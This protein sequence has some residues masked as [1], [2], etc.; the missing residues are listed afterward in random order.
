MLQRISYSVYRYIIMKNQEYNIGLDVGTNS[1]GWCVIDLEG[2]LLQFRKKNMWGARLFEAGETAEKC[3]LH[4][5]TRRRYERRRQ[6]IH[7]LQEIME[8]MI[9]DVD[10][11]FFIRLDEAFLW[12]EDKKVKTDYILF[13]D[14]GYTDI[15]FYK[16]YPTRYHLRKYLINTDEK[17]DPRMI[18]LT[19][20]HMIK[21]RG[22]FLYQGQKF[23][24]IASAQEAFKI[25][26][27]ELMDQL[28]IEITY[29]EECF[30][31]IETILKGEK[32]GKKTKQE[33]VVELLTK[34]GVDKKYAKELV[35]AFLGYSFDLTK[36]MKD[37]ELRD[38]NEKTIKVAFKDA[39][40]EETEA[41]LKDL[42]GE[43][44]SVVEALKRIYSWMA[45]EETL[46][47]KQY[48]SEAMVDKY[49]KHHKELAKLKALFRKYFTKEEYI[50]FFREEKMNGK[51]K[52]A[53]TYANYIQGT[54]RCDK[55]SL[56]DEIKKL[57]DKAAKED[58]DYQAALIEME[59]EEYLSKQN[60]VNNAYIPY[61]LNEMEL[62]LILQKQ[63]EFYP[64]L[65]ENKQKILKLLTF[66]IPYF[67]G[68]LNPYQHNQQ[69]NFAWM[70]KKEGKE[71]EKI[72][73]WNFNEVVDIDQTAEK[74][75]T[76]M[77]SFCTYLPEEKVLPKYSLLYA[78]YEVF[79][80]L[81]KIR[82]DGRL[83]PV[84]DKKKII[85]E[86]F[87]K[88]KNVTDKAFK[89]W[90]IRTQYGKVKEENEEYEVTGY[91]KE[92]GF[93]SSLTAYIDFTHI[94]GEIT[95]ENTKMIEELIYWLTVFEERDIVKRK[96]KQKYGEKITQ[97][98][99]K[100]I[101]KLQYTGWGKLSEK[102]LNGI[103]GYNKRH[104]KV[105][106][107]DVLRE[108]RRNLN[109]MQIINDREMEFYDII[110]EKRKRLDEN[111]TLL[112]AVNDL[113]G[114]PAIK[115]GIWQSLQIIE[116][117]IKIMDGV[118][119]QQIFI[120]FAREQGEKVRTTT[121]ARQLQNAYKKLKEEVKDFNAQ[122]EEELKNKENQ[123]KLDEEKAYLY[124]LQN[125]KSLYSGET[126]NLGELES[127]EVDH[128]IPRTM[129]K[130]DSLDN[131][132][133]VKKGENQKKGNH[134]VLEVFD[135]KKVQAMWNNLYQ[136]GLISPQKYANLQKETFEKRATKRFIHRQLVETRQIVK[137]VA[138]LI[139]DYYKDEIKAIEIKAN[140][141]SELRQT[142]TQE[143]KDENGCLIRNPD[144][145]TLLKS[146]T[147]N[148]FHHA[149]DAYLACVIGL[150][151]KAAY[152][153]YEEEIDYNEFIKYYKESAKKDKK[154]K[155]SYILSKFE[156]IF[157]D[158]EGVETWNGRKA[159]EYIKKIFAYRDCIITKKLEENTGA[160]YHETIYPKSGENKNTKL[161]P[162]K[163]GLDVSKYG[164]YQGGEAAYFTLLEYQQKN[165]KKL[166]LQ[167]IPIMD[168]KKIA[169][170]EMKLEEYLQEVLGT[171][172]VTIIRKKVQK[173]QLIEDSEG[174]RFYL[175]A[176]TEVVNAKQF[177]L[178]GK[179]QEFYWLIHMMEKGTYDKYNKQEV[180]KCMDEFYKFFK[181]KMKSQYSSYESI[182]SKIDN[183]GTYDTLESKLEEKRAFLLELLKLTKA[184][185]ECANMK[186]FNESKL[187]DRMGRKSGYSVKAGT[188]F[189]DQSVT[190][191]S[192]RRQTI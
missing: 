64:A 180:E 22:H 168:A 173:N 152:P 90:L 30:D 131:K 50:D 81:N 92:G 48:L 186:K 179:H 70:N 127:Y 109:L 68:P 73:P 126:L 142:Y 125:G 23:E 46:R 26:L 18:Y 5:S 12:K 55:K 24:A 112:E 93:A 82:V 115:R 136:C 37:D 34:Q 178:G 83:L 15:Q 86:V 52:Y 54:G 11:S 51:D 144:G 78:E 139:G 27:Q 182:I 43:K 118:K 141:S 159:L 108:D 41:E 85:E 176:A 4:R 132:A 80:E 6:R 107:M 146:R 104:E 87:K 151:I 8:P 36:I 69:R 58:A 32:D 145:Y 100:K 149:Q 114:S 113:H 156:K 7:L 91:Q 119:P 72:Y 99:L 177:V 75:I 189:I 94:F 14:K 95:F 165:K 110:K 98:Q 101:L 150:Y 63:G 134:L 62:E 1:V 45:M 122:A 147:I 56:Y 84:E 40:Y 106:I 47:G 184:N 19:L 135:R 170:G 66:R 16:E 61:Q 117:I 166:I 65:K 60:E 38:E 79:Q 9:L 102:F 130:D 153:K 76:R 190:G 161:L 25:L 138:N 137:N 35:G 129:I 103:K 124:Y 2:K 157:Y 155:F 13:Q 158:A 148:D 163:K 174:N 181:E 154:Q 67:V 44:F 116:E 172:Q 42:L 89:R 111:T 31:M 171:E 185:P 21:Y 49:E 121:R 167:G 187:A 88:Q 59:K 123:K 175:T 33:K 10:K 133:L 39:K 17:A 53:P 3:R 169:S 160:F 28:K 128:I 77:T 140:L 120:E 96:I 162:L 192:E 97:A 183:S 71:E 29:S 164:G 57:L 74:F 143:E 105:T 191:L 20:H 188:T